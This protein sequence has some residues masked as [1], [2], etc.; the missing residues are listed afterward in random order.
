MVRMNKF[1][2]LPHLTPYEI[3]YAQWSVEQARLLR[4]GRLDLLDREHLAEE[5]ED[6][7]RREKREIDSRLVQV[8]LHLLKW[9]FQP[10]KRKGGWEASIRVHR[11]D[12][13]EVLSENPS[14]RGYAEKRLTTTYAKAR[15]EAEKETGIAYETFP[16]RCPYTTA[17][18]LDD[19][20]F[21]N[22]V[23]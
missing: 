23:D 15:L 12:L 22:R 10:E 6:L 21:P 9:Q 19:S 4:E 17:Q 7:G 14:L 18:V 8:L 20:F 11:A 5:I 2:K 3:D 13:K 16:D 1:S